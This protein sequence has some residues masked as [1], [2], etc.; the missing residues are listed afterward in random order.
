MNNDETLKKW[1]ELSPPCDGWTPKG[2]RILRCQITQITITQ[3]CL[4]ELKEGKVTML[5][6]K[7]YFHIEA[8]G[9][10]PAAITVYP[11]GN[12]SDML[13]KGESDDLEDQVGIGYWVLPGF[14]GVF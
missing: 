10:I 14:S 3:G 6:D 12:Y 11:A 5:G 1:K 2:R 13:L 4:G 8:T 7:F 9:A